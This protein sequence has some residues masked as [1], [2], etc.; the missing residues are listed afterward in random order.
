MYNYFLKEK[1]EKEKQERDLNKERMKQKEIKR[2]SKS[3]LLF[4]FPKI[5]LYKFIIKEQMKKL[6]ENYEKRIKNF[7]LKLAEKP[8]IVKKQKDKHLTSRE[9]YYAN[10]SNKIIDKKG[11]SFKYYKTEK[12]R[13][14]EYIKEIKNIDNYITKNISKKKRRKS[15]EIKL[16]QPSM[17]FKARTDL[18]RVYDVL[19]NREN[20]YKDKKIVQKQLDNL[21]FVSKNYEEFDDFDEDEEG[22]EEKNKKNL[23]NFEND[24]KNKNLNSEERKRKILHNKII[25]DRK[26]MIERRKIF[27]TLGNNNKIKNKDKEN[28]PKF[29]LREELHQKLHFKALENLTMFKT[30][31]MNHNLFKIWSK[32]D[33]KIQKN[34]TFNKNIYYAGLTNGFNI[35]EPKIQSIEPY[36]YK[37]N[38]NVNNNKINDT[39]NKSNK[40][41]ESKVISNF[42][43]NSGLLNK[44]D[45]ENQ[46][47]YNIF[48]NKKILE[49]LELTKE[50]VKSNPLLFN[51][52][53]NSVRTL[54]NNKKSLS[55]NKLSNLK[56]I[57]FN[58]NTE[59]NSDIYDEAMK[60]EMQFDDLKKEENVIIDGKQFKKSETYK[61]ADKILKKCNWNKNKVKYNGYFG[62]GKLMFTNGMTLKEFEEKYR[63]L[64]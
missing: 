48:H 40:G 23:E 37:K 53:F 38:K 46:K 20:F 47:N 7:V 41:K 6:V 64:P 3:L 22:E 24:E 49:D 36:N 58:Y 26:N 35:A 31:T 9:E 50:I 18:E 56:E 29:H 19:K 52:N 15:P 39:I 5:I 61:I 63:I 60:N 59:D 62:K 43:N 28:K 21:G 57:A 2:K 54:G 45:I 13:I 16:I 8:I 55:N 4:Y 42:I 10:N 17:R 11:F 1:I 33:I 32:E 12:E 14:N 30:S 34:L 44:K 27:L 25:Q 51:Y